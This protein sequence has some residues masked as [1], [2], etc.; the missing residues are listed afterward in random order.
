M[1]SKSCEPNKYLQ[2]LMAIHVIKEP[3]IPYD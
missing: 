3:L 1:I 2:A